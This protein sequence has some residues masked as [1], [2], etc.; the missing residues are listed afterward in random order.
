M[1]YI[2]NEPPQI[3]AY[4]YESFNGGGTS[5]TLSKTATT[6]SVLLFID[7]VR[8]T[9][10]D[11]FSVSGT[12]LTTT[13]ATPSGTSNVT[14][15]FLGDVVDFGAP[16]DDSVTSAKIVDG[17]IVDADINASAAIS[18]SKLASTL[19]L[20]SKTVTLPATSVSASQ[21]ASTLDLSSKTVTLPAAS[22]TAHVTEYDDNNVKNDIALLG[23]QVASNGSLAKY[24]LVDQTSDAFESEAGID[25]STSS[26]EVYNSSGKYYSSV[27]SE[28]AL[29][30][31]DSTW[32]VTGFTNWNVAY[33]NG[34]GSNVGLLSDG[35]GA[36]STVN[37]DLGSGVAKAITKITIYIENNTQ[38]DF[39]EV[40]YSDD[41]WTTST[42]IAL[43]S[44][45]LGGAPTS[46]GSRDYTATWSNPGAHRYWRL[47]KGNSASN[48]SWS[49]NCRLFET[50]VAA[51]MNLVSNSTTAEAAPSKF[52]I[53]LTWS[54]G[55]GSGTLNT[56][57][58]AEC[59]ADN[60]STWTSMTLVSEG[61]TGSH[62]IAAAHDVT[63]TSTSG[64]S[65]RYRIKTLNQSTSKETRIHAV[66]QGWS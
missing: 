2:G 43:G 62:N 27:G 61:T 53:V 32:S 39:D 59:S 38:L 20:S 1:P 9:P 56:D 3:A 8:Q 65:C 17:A 52:D 64:T 46:G 63:R 36:G 23:F 33:W 35:V 48:G 66:S 12:T 29:S 28:T 40:R 5:F 45:V 7:G 13:A 54:D 41:N 51:T 50:P 21:L 14:V 57:L 60:G 6:A 37:L 24:N 11:A 42:T 19:D 25:T 31:D 55:T 4:G 10:I 47:R 15:Q 22:V 58:T 34:T 44:G 16:S 30:V 49:S 18:A 26:D